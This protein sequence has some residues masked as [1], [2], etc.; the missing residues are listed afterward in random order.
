MSEF[1]NEYAK[2][3]LE[4]DNVDS[5]MTHDALMAHFKDWQPPKELVEVP[6]FV[7]DWFENAK[8]NLEF[9]IWQYISDWRENEQ[10]D[11]WFWFS[12]DENKPTET[13][14]RMKLEGYTVKKEQLY[15]L[16]FPKQLNAFVSSTGK[17]QD[18]DVIISGYTSVKKDAKRF[19]EQEIKALDE[20]LMAFA[21]KVD[22]VDVD[23]LEVKE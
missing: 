14:I 6:Q 19:T 2:L 21:V 8:G 18:N 3:R 15:V 4:L 10:N 12:E 16:E 1:E 22:E 17:N 5:L 7:A 20:R 9:V 13:L 11:F 23:T